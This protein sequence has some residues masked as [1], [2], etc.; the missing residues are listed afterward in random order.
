MLSFYCC[1]DTTTKK[2]FTKPVTLDLQPLGFCDMLSVSEDTA[3]WQ[4]FGQIR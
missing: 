4:S 1:K 3:S 2:L